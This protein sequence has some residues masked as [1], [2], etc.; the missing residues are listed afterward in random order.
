[1]TQ[2]KEICT[3]PELSTISEHV[4]YFLVHV[5]SCVCDLHWIY[6]T[7]I[8][9][10]RNLCARDL[11]CEIWLLGCVISRRYLSYLLSC[12]LCD[13]SSALICWRKKFALHKFLI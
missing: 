13:Q 5:L 3:K 12:L 9:G 1:V 11:N 8:F 6:W 7:A 2:G 4:S 10:A